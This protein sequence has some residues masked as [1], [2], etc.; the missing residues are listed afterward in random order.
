MNTYYDNK[1][2][3]HFERAL[4][5]QNGSGSEIAFDFDPASLDPLKIIFDIEGAESVTGSYGR[6][7]RLIDIT[8]TSFPFDFY[9]DYM[10]VYKLNNEG[11][12][13]NNV[14]EPSYNFS[15]YVHGLKQSIT[16]GSVGCTSCSA[17]ISHQNI[18]LRAADFISLEDGFEVDD[19]SDT[20]FFATVNGSCDN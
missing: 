11:C 8:Q 7:C 17:V 3:Y 9:I 5:Y 6:F 16:F 10:N 1:L 19:T 14:N 4:F 20:E 2:V 18:S 13:N 12:V 15:N